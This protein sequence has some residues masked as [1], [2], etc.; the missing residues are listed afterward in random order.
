MSRNAVTWDIG[1]HFRTKGVCC[2]VSFSR[3]RRIHGKVD[4]YFG[5]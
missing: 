4:A 2:A 3:M 5:V 1:W